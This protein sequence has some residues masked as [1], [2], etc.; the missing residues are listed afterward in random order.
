ME[1]CV[2]SRMGKP[3]R[4]ALGVLNGASRHRV[5]VYRY[6]LLSPLS[7]CLH[8]EL[9]GINKIRLE[10]NLWRQKGHPWRQKAE[11]GDKTHRYRAFCRPFSVPATE[12]THIGV[13][14]LQL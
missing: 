6:F 4:A 7:L 12:L 3:E 10:I 2:F 1:T 9:S 11:F 8:V 14:K 5:Y 13:I